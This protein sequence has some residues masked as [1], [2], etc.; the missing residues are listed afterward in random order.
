[1][2]DSRPN[3]LFIISDQHSK[4]HLGCYGDPLVRTPHLDRLAAEGMRLTNTYTAAP[5]CVPARMAF[6]TGRHPSKTEVWTNGHILNS[7]VPTWAHA[8]GAA[9]YETALI[10]RMHFVGPDQRHGFAKRPIGEYSA[11]HPGANRLG[12]PMFKDIPA[13]TS[14]QIRAAVEIAGYGRTTYQAFDEQVAE[15]GVAYLREKARGG[16]PFATVAGFVLPHCPFFAP[17]ELFDHYYARVDVPELTAAELA[18]EPEAIKRFKQTRQIDRPLPEERI[19]VARAA[20][21]GL[22][23]Y[24]DA[25]VGRLLDALDETGLAANTLVIYLSDHGEMAGEHGCWWKS[26]YY[27]GSVGVPLIARWPG[28][29]AAGA[30]DDTLCSLLDLGPLAIELAG[31]EPLPAADGHS[32]WPVLQGRAD[33]ARP[34]AIF[35]ELG[36]M[37]GEPPSRMIRQERWKLYQYGDDMPPALFD[38][39]ADPGEWRDLGMDGDCAVVREGL[40]TRLYRDWDPARVTQRSAALACD[41]QAIAAWGQALQ[42]RHP[43]T[44]SVPDV[45]A[46]V[47]V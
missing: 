2:S 25:Q 29:I 7:A 22:C 43:D 17:K 13:S 6:M 11:H 46:V 15:A 21:L 26:N 24:F 40:L 5:V 42:P 14:G 44:L 31:G 37:R 28:V 33:P 8:V 18:G 39:A 1:M 4:Y 35:S 3:I 9:G 38:L 12:G 27:E 16:S 10:G 36:P 41:A 47:R 23:E 45:E 30:V 34:D 19:R 32:L 20:Y